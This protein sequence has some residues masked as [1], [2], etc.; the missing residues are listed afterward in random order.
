MAMRR[1]P[2]LPGS[3]RAPFRGAP[4]SLCLLLLSLSLLVPACQKD[5]DKLLKPGSVASNLVTAVY[6]PPNE[7]HGNE[8]K[9]DGEAKDREWG[10]PLDIDRPYTQIRLTSADGTGDPGEPIY[11][12]MKAVYTDTDVYFLLRWRDDAPNAMK[13]AL[14]Y[15]GP[16]LTARTGRQE[17]LTQE[18]S[19]ARS[20]LRY[21]QED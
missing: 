14:Q 6:I 13:D 12:S 19:W 9:M 15:I 20:S 11:C 10:G 1:T 21:D 16:D 5:D 2:S 17:I 8:I 3:G 7:F 18:S 4:V